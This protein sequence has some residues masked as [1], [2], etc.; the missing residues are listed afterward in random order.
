[1]Q[2]LPNTNRDPDRLTV[3][4][5]TGVT[6]L[7]RRTAAEMETRGYG[8]PAEVVGPRLAQADITVISNEVPFIEGCTP[9]TDLN[10][11]VFCSKPEYMETLLASGVSIVGLTG[12]HQNDFGWQGMRDSLEVYAQH[13]IPVYG[14]GNNRE[15]AT[16]PLYVEHNGN[17]LAFLGVNSFGPP[18]A[19]AT[20]SAPGSAP[21]DLAIFSATIRNIKQQGLADVV[22]AEFQYQES[23]DVEPLWEQRNDFR[24][25]VRAGA[26]IVT[27]VQSHVPQAIE[28]INPAWPPEP[29]YSDDRLI[30]YGLGN[31]YFDQMGSDPTRENLIALHTIYA[32]RHLSTQLLTTFLY[33]YGQ[34]R[35]PEPD[36]HDSIL[37]RVFAASN[38]AP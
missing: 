16:A 24:A 8:W 22:L 29:G 7:T 31:L 36:H 20:E 15:E 27:G 18:S 11:L 1:L 17:R 37:Q 35:W 28:F 33:D 21:Y 32:G 38:F 23:Y 25:V 12:N 6:A 26:D 13:G 4:A 5:A 2:A 34:P 19:W 10:N 14:G 9:N 30:L 3:V